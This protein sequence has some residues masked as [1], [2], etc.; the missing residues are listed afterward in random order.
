[1]EDNIRLP[2]SDRI[3]EKRQDAELRGLKKTLIEAVLDT[4]RPISV[5]MLGPVS[6]NM[7]SMLTLWAKQD[8][9]KLD[10]IVNTEKQ[11]DYADNEYYG[12]QSYWLNL[13]R[14]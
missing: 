13:S 8:G 10:Y 3:A 12:T 6:E 14:I 11:M 2:S 4:K 5:H 7:I 1:M 9:W